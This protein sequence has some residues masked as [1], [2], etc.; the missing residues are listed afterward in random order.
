[1][2]RSM[3]NASQYRYGRSMKLLIAPVAALLLAVTGYG[4]GFNESPA[5]LGSYQTSVTAGNYGAGFIGSPTLLYGGVHSAF[6]P[7][8]PGYGA[9]FVQ[10]PRLY[11][12]RTYTPFY[13]MYYNPYPSSY[14]YLT[15]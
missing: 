2:M 3:A 12:Y 11:G 4:A 9:G 5:G 7:L 13:P 14:F 6:P 8:R 15:F 1:M 10:S